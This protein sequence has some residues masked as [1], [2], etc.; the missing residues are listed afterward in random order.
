MLGNTSDCLTYT[1]WSGEDM[2]V[3][4]QVLLQILSMGSFPVLLWDHVVLGLEVGSPAC[5][6]HALS[7]KLSFEP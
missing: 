3:G 2:S 5:K 6:E 4:V 1:S 7:I